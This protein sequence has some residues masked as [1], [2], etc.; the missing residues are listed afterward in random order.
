MKIKSYALYVLIGILIYFLFS[1]LVLPLFNHSIS[2]STDNSAIQNNEFLKNR[3][4]ELRIENSSLNTSTI[5]YNSDGNPIPINSLANTNN[6]FFR[7]SESSCSPCIQD[8]TVYI[9]MMH[10]AKI[11]NPIVLI[12]CGNFGHFKSL[13]KHL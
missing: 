8:Q 9:N 7:F 12:E 10:K 13:V 4:V 1:F 5:I 2:N 3:I 11:C 6:L